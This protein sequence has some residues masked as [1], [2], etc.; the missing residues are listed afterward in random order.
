MGNYVG[1]REQFIDNYEP[2]NKAQNET[3]C[4]KFFKMFFDDELIELIVRETNIYAAQKI[5]Q[6]KKARPSRRC[7][8][9]YKNNRRKEAVFLCPECEAPCVEESSKAFHTKLNF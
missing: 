6:K 9:C 7:V 3:H 5:H 8:V 2:Q 1:Q 4:A